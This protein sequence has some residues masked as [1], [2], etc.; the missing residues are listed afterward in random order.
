V[1][2]HHHIVEYPPPKN[3]LAERIGTTLINGRWFTRRLQRVADRAVVMHGHRHIDWIGQCGG[4]SIVSAPSVVMESKGAVDSYF[5]VHT[6]GV[7]RDG[8]LALL[9]PERVVVRGDGAAAADLS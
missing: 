4:L 9:E 2:L 5:Y 8:R 6:L 3:G 7:D 1:A